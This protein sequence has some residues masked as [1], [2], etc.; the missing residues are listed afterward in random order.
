MNVPETLSKESQ[1][2]GLPAEYLQ[3]NWPQIAPL[4][5]KALDRMSAHDKMNKE[6]ILSKLLNREWQCW[7]AASEPGKIEVVIMTFIQVYP[8]GYKELVI[9][10][11]GG[12]NLKGWMHIAWD[13]MKKFARHHK[14]G[15]I[16]GVGRTSWMTLAKRL[17]I[18]VKS[19]EVSFTFEVD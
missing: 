1:F 6:F 4:I 8:T 9:V 14:C 19:T 7:V 18:P 3:A 13:T 15:N 5:D 10:L 16:K 12:S 11:I 2:S 17:G